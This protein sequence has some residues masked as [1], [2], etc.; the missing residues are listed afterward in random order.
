MTIE[1]ML[2]YDFLIFLLRYPTEVIKNINIDSSILEILYKFKLHFLIVLSAKGSIKE[3]KILHRLT[4]SGI[5]SSY[6]LSQELGIPSAT[7]WRLLK[8]LH[9]EGYVHKENKGFSITPNGLFILYKTYREDRVRKLVAKRL[10]ELWNYEGEVEDIYALLDDISKLIDND[11]IKIKSLCFSL[12]SSLVGFLF[13][14]SNELSERSKRVLAYYI[15]KT[16]PTVNITPLCKAVISFDERGIP[17][18]IA[19]NCKVEGQK[20]NHYCKAIQK[21]FSKDK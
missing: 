9:K 13:P 5:E 14:F 17:Y 10:K 15:T 18:A 21:L 12:P 6:R 8:K 7:S 3:L 4:I 2:L 19:T 11:K 16:F 20:I 1:F